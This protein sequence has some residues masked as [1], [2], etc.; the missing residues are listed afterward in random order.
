MPG[1]LSAISCILFVKF[2]RVVPVCVPKVLVSKFPSV[3]VS[4][5]DSISVSDLEHFYYFLPLFAISWIS[6][7]DIFIPP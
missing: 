2:S 1:V 7:R 5:I 6:L 4:F 3:L